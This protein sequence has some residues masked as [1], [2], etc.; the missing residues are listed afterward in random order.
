MTAI[1][2]NVQAPYN[3]TGA[4]QTTTLPNGSLGKE[5]FL[6]LLVAQLSHQDPMKPTDPTEFVSQLSQFSSLEQLMNLKDGLD[7]LAVTQTAGTS[8]Q[9]V[10]FIGK[11]VVFEGSQVKWET[12]EQPPD[13]DFQ[14][15]DRAATATV[16][17]RDTSGQEVASFDLGKLTAGN[18]H[19]SLAGHDLPPGTYSVEIIAKDAAGNN[20]PVAQQATGVVAGVTF[21]HGY[22]EIILVGGRTLGLG[23]IIKVLGDAPESGPLAT[24]LPD[25]DDDAATSSAPTVP[26][27]HLPG[28]PQPRKTTSPSGTHIST[29]PL[30]TSRRD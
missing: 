10:S 8:A 12:G 9:M 30:F 28:Q 1:S 14:L 13:A 11:S 27:I 20:L 22:P 15:K 25:T 4:A 23:Q 26:Q 6:S 24:P 17:V 5:D 29:P 3:P 18:H 7:L 2:N 19:V 16:K 21:E